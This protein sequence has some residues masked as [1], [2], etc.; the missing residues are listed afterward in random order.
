MLIPP[1]CVSPFVVVVDRVP[2]VALRSF[3]WVSGSN[4]VVFIVRWMVI[5]FWAV[6][7]EVPP[8]YRLTRE[9]VGRKLAFGVIGIRFQLD[10]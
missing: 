9:Q 6:V 4:V 1:Q 10:G 8:N 5:W 3:A 7:L 2:S